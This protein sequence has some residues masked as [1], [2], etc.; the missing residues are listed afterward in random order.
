MRVC[1]ELCGAREELFHAQLQQA[2]AEVLQR[3]R[4]LSAPG[5]QL[6]S[7]MVSSAPPTEC[8]MHISPLRLC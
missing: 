3:A 8:S 1:V 5:D 4:L 7:P 2:G 6:S